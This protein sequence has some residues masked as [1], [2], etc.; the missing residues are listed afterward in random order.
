M[1]I[2]GC[3]IHYLTYKEIITKKHGGFKKCVEQ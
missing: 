2:G 1:Y 3:V